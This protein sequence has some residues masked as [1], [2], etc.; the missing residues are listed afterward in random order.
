[1]KLWPFKAPLVIVALKVPT[2]SV[3]RLDF[4]NQKQKFAEVSTIATIMAGCRIIMRIKGSGKTAEI[5]DLPNT[6][7]KSW[8][9]YRN[10]G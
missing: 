1:M 7:Y 4:S 2:T 5:A 3:S 10:R 6:K 8:R 9:I